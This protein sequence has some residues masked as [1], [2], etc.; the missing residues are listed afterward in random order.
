MTPAS[1]LSVK[2]TRIR[3]PMPSPLR[4]FDSGPGRTGAATAGAATPEGT[5]QAAEGRSRGS[6]PPRE[7][8]G[9]SPDTRLHSPS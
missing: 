2:N 3:A 7:D 6:R 4:R 8:H 9:I 5:W 1:E